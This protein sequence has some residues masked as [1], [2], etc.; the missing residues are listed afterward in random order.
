MKSMHLS[1]HLSKHHKSG[2][3]A[4]EGAEHS[5]IRVLPLSA[6]SSQV[7]KDKS[8]AC[9]FSL[10]SVTFYAAGDFSINSS[11]VFTATQSPER[12]SAGLGCSGLY[13]RGITSWTAVRLKDAQLCS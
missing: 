2:T 1:P 4:R 12:R 10:E 3:Y 7:Q 13:E 6:M 5:F 8:K 9:G 11:L